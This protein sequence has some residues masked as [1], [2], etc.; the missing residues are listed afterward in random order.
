MYLNNGD[1]EI[2]G[3]KFI[4]YSQMG[5]E[6][7]FKDTAKSLVL[8][9]VMGL[10]CSRLSVHTMVSVWC[11]IMLWVSVVL[12]CL[13]TQWFPF[14][15]VLCYGSLLFLSVCTHNGFHSIILVLVDRSF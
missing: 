1:R 9:Y 5:E 4:N 2:H 15:A 12:V 7:I 6:L 11:C 14:G 8:Y 13:Y 3:C 10:C